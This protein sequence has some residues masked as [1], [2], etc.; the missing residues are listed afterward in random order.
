MNTFSTTLPATDPRA[1]AGLNFLGTGYSPIAMPI[2]VLA[3]TNSMSAVNTT[4]LWSAANLAKSTGAPAGAPTGTMLSLD[5]AEQ[6]IIR[7][8]TAIAFPL[9]VGTP[10]S[11][12][13][14]L[15]MHKLFAEIRRNARVEGL[16]DWDRKA[17][18]DLQ[19]GG[20]SR[21]RFPAANGAGRSRVAHGQSFRPDCPGP[22]AGSLAS[23]VVC[24]LSAAVPVAAK[25]VMCMVQPSFPIGPVQDTL[26]SEAADL[27]PGQA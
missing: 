21:S 10:I 15:G 19:G 22:A 2:P 3:Q 17:I 6:R 4:R 27:H 23:K 1:R 24:R 18:S 5:A 26:C 9:Y 16:A 11:F 14:D 25:T 20:R 7:T 12:F 13:C 8:P